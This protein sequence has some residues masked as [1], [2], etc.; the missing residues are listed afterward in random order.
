MSN[1]LLSTLAAAPV[2]G[3][4]GSKS[5]GGSWFEAMADAW[6]Q[7]LDRQAGDIETKSAAMSAGGDKP[8][9]VTELTAMS[10][11]M[12]F[13]ASSSHTAVSTVGSALETMARKQ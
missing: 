1:A 7:A 10:L 13:L 3:S 11:K 2:N 8:A 5:S 9:D 6:G 12:S 4:T